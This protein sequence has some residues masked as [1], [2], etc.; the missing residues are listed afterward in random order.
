MNR[1]LPKPQFLSSPRNQRLL[2]LFGLLVLV[3]QFSDPVS[4]ASLAE[5]V[6]FWGVRVAG[7]FASLIV[8]DW[9]KPAISA[10]A[11]R[12]FHGASQRPLC[13]GG[14]SAG[15]ACATSQEKRAA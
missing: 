3:M 10:G 15:P 13:K 8:A 11:R 5:T 6:V 9:L 2:V 7:V 4:N 1:P 14:A 12:R